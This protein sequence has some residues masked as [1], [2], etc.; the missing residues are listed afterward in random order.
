MDNL[1]KKLRNTIKSGL[2]PAEVLVSVIIVVKNGERTVEKAINSVTSQTYSR[3]ELVVIDGKSEDK[4]LDIV[5][6]Y[7]QNVNILVSEIDNGIYD[8]MNKAI[9]LANGDLIY[10]LGSDDYF[11]S[12]NV[13]DTIVSR[14]SNTKAD[15]LY[16]NIVVYNAKLQRN[17]VKYGELFVSDLKRGIFPQHQ[18]SFMKKAVIQENGCFDTNFR[19]SAD[20]DLIAKI[21]MNKKYKIEFVNMRIAYFGTSGASSS[22]GIPSDGIKI[23]T[24]NFG[25][26]FGIKLACAYYITK[27]IKDV[28][29][30]TKLIKLYHRLAKLFS[31][32]L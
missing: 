32:N 28:A 11:Y 22:V 27:I 3:I 6:K 25:V 21:Y 17:E 9:N 7:S 24:K 1:T 8:A 4:T 12:E 31:D 20:S 16:G 14:F 13:V 10:F 23:L 15:F 18:S 26:F 30:K 29:Y 2:I 19:I 5:K